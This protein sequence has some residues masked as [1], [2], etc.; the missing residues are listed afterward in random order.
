MIVII[1]FISTFF[2]P[3]PNLVKRNIKIFKLKK[4][5]KNTQTIHK[6]KLARISWKQHQSDSM[7]MTK[8]LATNSQQEGTIDFLVRKKNLDS[9]AMVKLIGINKCQKGNIAYLKRKINSLQKKLNKC[10]KEKPATRKL[11]KQPIVIKKQIAIKTEKKPVVKDLSDIYYESTAKIIY[12][13]VDLGNNPG[14]YLPHLAILN[15]EDFGKNA[16]KNNQGG[17]N[18][19]INKLSSKI[20]GDYGVTEEGIFF[21]SKKLIDRY[22]SQSDRGLVEIK[23]TATNWQLKK[24]TISGNY[25]IFKK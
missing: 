7:A 22:I 23:T 13:C 1:L 20:T 18:L 16:Q 17:Y 10:Q 9:L 6:I 19:V 14:H 2:I 5:T 25:Y 21:I 3:A 11:A 24:M 8:L 4:E 15:G 12:F